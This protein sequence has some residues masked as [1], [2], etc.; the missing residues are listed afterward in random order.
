M[1]FG[2][3]LACYRATVQPLDSRLFSLSDNEQRDGRPSR[4]GR[5]VDRRFLL[6]AAIA[7]SLLAAAI[8]AVPLVVGYLATPDGHLR[9]HGGSC[10]L[11]P[12]GGRLE[13]RGAATYVGDTAVAWPPGY[14]SVPVGPGVL[15]VR[16]I[17]GGEE[18]RTGEMV[19]LTGGYTD[20]DSEWQVCWVYS[21]DGIRQDPT[22]AVQSAV[23]VSTQRRVALGT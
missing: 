11:A 7:V 8:I 4:G 15:S 20:N 6:A 18:A 17:W 10:M 9:T 3:L 5:T 16:N 22:N 21:R 2:E 1:T 23:A 13:A 19:S 14:Y 12:M